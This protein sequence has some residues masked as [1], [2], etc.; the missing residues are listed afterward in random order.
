MSL[1]VVEMLQDIDK[2]PELLNTKYKTSAPM[3]IVFEYAFIPDNKFILP[4]G[5]PPFK[6]DP[7]PLTMS[8]S[9]FIMELRRLYIFTKKREDLAAIRR[10]ALFIQLLESIHPSEAKVLLAIKD[11]KLDEL[12][13][14][15]TFE[16]VVAAGFI[17][18]GTPFRPDQTPVKT[19]AKRGPKPKPKTD[20]PKKVGAKRGPKPK[21][22][23]PVSEEPSSEA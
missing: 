21:V 20:E 4:E 16:R 5:D 18:E 9:N 1:T 3:R 7:A 19:P 11:Q 17:P 15:I 14:N 13:K 12:F 8:R 23:A 10:E 22:A 6:P 2:N